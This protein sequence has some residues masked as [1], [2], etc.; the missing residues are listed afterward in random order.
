[1]GGAFAIRMGGMQAG[2]K[3]AA[4]TAPEG[5]VDLAVHLDP[6]T[7]LVHRLQF[8]AWAKQD[9]RFGN[10][11]I[12]RAGPAGGAV[13][14]VNGTPLTE[15][16]EDATDEPAKDAPLLYENGLPKRPRKKMSVSDY[17]VQLQG[18]GKTPAAELS[19][20]QKLLLGH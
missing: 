4:A 11:R 16:D 1:M 14:V 19:D 13:Q 6:A 9:A 8:R 18:H 2:A 20:R 15:E 3:R 7:G 17:T 5:T 12:M 10:V